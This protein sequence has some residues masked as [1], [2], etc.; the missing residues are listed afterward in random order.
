MFAVHAHFA[1]PKELQNARELQKN[2]SGRRMML[3][4]GGQSTWA[5]KFRSSG[6]VLLEDLWRSLAY[7]ALGKD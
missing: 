4:K 7:S 1:V 3:E 6:A 2:L 5:K